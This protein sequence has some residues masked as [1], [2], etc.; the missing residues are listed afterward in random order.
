MILSLL[1]PLVQYLFFCLISLFTGRGILK[2]IFP[3]DQVNRSQ[4]LYPIV[5]LTF[6]SLFL[7]IGVAFF[8]PL[9]FLVYSLCIATLLLAIFGIWM[10]RPF[11]LLTWIGITLLAL[12]LSLPYVI[13]G[14]S[15]FLGSPA[16][17]GWAYA[18]TGSISGNIYAAPKAA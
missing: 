12:I 5:S 13:H 11:K 15:N 1:M 18:V 17:N 10:F 7:G 14:F 2:C 9:R 6:W 8:I 3:N 4:F 16:P